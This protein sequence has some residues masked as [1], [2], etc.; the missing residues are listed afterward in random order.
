MSEQERSAFVS[1]AEVGEVL[2]T[3]AGSLTFKAT[4]EQTGGALT[5]WETSA[6]P[7]D[8]PPFHLHVREDEAIY[9]LKGLLRVRLEDTVEE[10]PAGSFVFFPNGVPH[11]WQNGGKT[12]ARILVVFTP[13]VP[14]MERFF[15]RA[16]K[17]PDETRFADA[18]GRF[19]DDAGMVV[20]GP[21]LA[22]SHPRSGK[23]VHPRANAERG[24]RAGAG[25]QTE[26][27]VK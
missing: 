25:P 1:A 12:T 14:G 22:Q 6:P 7:G 24:V 4:G 26:D 11:T 9:V 23:E 17:L 5:A 21:P 15:Q 18:F 10:A 8:G 3:P 13:A 27:A 20:L 16:A 2:A 19:A